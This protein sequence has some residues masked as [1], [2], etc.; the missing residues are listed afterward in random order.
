MSPTKHLVNTDLQ[1][2]RKSQFYI[3]FLG[4]RKLLLH[5]IPIDSI[6]RS[7]LI[8]GQVRRVKNAMFLFI[9]C[10][11]ALWMIHSTGACC[12]Y[13][14]SSPL[15]SPVPVCVTTSSGGPL[16]DDTL[17][18]LFRV[19]SREA[20]QQSSPTVT[21]LIRPTRVPG[22]MLQHAIWQHFFQEGHWYPEGSV[23]TQLNRRNRAP[24]VYKYVCL[25][26]LPA[27]GYSH[28]HKSCITTPNHVLRV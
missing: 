24:S 10:A 3:L 23:F 2:D 25:L 5:S 6:K 13:N 15:P 26:A 20:G 28:Y 4:F 12:L 16:R 14:S 19:R 1:A 17:C 9:Q 18:L 8:G 27:E 21:E 7:E 11:W 22:S